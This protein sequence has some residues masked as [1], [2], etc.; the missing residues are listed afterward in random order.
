MSLLLSAVRC[1]GTE[2][3]RVNMH[4]HLAGSCNCLYSLEASSR[5][6]LAEQYCRGRCT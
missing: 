1:G 4:D 5:V 6:C 2:Q 3:A